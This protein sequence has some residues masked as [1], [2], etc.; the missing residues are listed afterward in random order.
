MVFTPL[1][2]STCVGT[3]EPRSVALPFVRLQKGFSLPYN[4]IF[5]GCAE[6][7]RPQDRVV[8]CVSEDG[9]HFDVSY[10]KLVMWAPLLLCIAFVPLRMMTRA[11]RLLADVCNCAAVQSYGQPGMH[12]GLLLPLHVVQCYAGLRYSSQWTVCQPLMPRR[13][14]RSGHQEWKNVRFLDRVLNCAR[15]GVL[16]HS[17][18]ITGGECVQLLIHSAMCPTLRPSATIC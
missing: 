17:L 12:P 6:N 3:V 5:G 18:T 7:V 14:R 1:L 15:A 9:I 16:G 13:A 11:P 2:P 4:S 10:D 8:P